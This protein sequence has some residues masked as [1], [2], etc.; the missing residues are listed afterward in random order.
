MSSLSILYS[1]KITEQEKKT[2]LF[3]IN[4]QNHTKKEIRKKYDEAM[5]FSSENFKKDFQVN[6]IFFHIVFS[7]ILI[8]KMFVI[9][10]NFINNSISEIL[11]A[12]SFSALVFIILIKSFI[13]LSFKYLPRSKKHVKLY[14]L[15]LTTFS[16][17][18]FSFTDPRCLGK[19]L[20][21]TV[22]YTE[23]TSLLYILSTI[24]LF[25]DLIY[26]NSSFTTI[27]GVLG[28]LCPNLMFLLSI[29]NDY[30]EFF[31]EMTIFTIIVLYIV[32]F[33]SR[34]GNHQSALYMKIYEQEKE[35]DEANSLSRKSEKKFETDR[36][37]LISSC[38]QVF[39]LLKHIVAIFITEKLY[40]EVMIAIDN[41]EK[42]Q[43]F[44]VKM[45]VFIDDYSS[46]D[47]Y[48]E[49]TFNSLNSLNSRKNSV[50]QPIG[51]DDTLIG[52]SVDWKFDILNVPEVGLFN[53]LINKVCMKFPGIIELLDNQ[54]SEFNSFFTELQKNYNHLPYHGAYHAADVLHNILCLLKIT[55]IENFKSLDMLITIVSALGHDVKHPGQS[56]STQ[57]NSLSN[58][59]LL[60][61][62][63]SVLENMHCSL[64]F[65][66]LLLDHCNFTKKFLPNDFKVF[67]KQVIEMILG[68][69]AMY[70]F[71]AAGK[72][73][74]MVDKYMQFFTE[75]EALFVQSYAL[76]CADVGHYA[77][78]W[79][80]YEK[81]AERIKLEFI[82][83]FNDDQIYES[84]FHTP[85]VDFD[86]DN[87]QIITTIV[88][89]LYIAW[90]CYVDSN[91]KELINN[92]ETNKRVNVVC[93]N[94]TTIE[95]FDI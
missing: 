46:L 33:T 71:E 20:G 67:R 3:D 41:I 65:N 38:K 60:Y 36:E 89:P 19:R 83:S 25:K 51:E 12:I 70:F 80:I 5:F 14:Y 81:W 73:K 54:I 66:I 69:D 87:K 18:F 94:I 56:N 53:K 8:H 42:I 35:V 76:K 29:R 78:D 21:E 57:I 10:G 23:H 9:I 63:H 45:P 24:V 6:M 26:N 61:N 82:K 49:N 74:A 43:A 2:H 11:F 15:L 95:K 88:L 84:S 48:N 92:I 90:D 93:S 27:V 77:K 30:F 34:Q 37:K 28:I 17:V 91:I 58:L 86:N 59:T 22:N 4:S 31:S 1:N 44:L 68:T 7:L 47:Q 13:L 39:Y 16:I 75:G 55:R 85:I 52:F 64:V 62:D 79:N 40:K 32:V 50:A 72:M